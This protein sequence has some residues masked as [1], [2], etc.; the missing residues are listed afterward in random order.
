MG[1]DMNERLA[2]IEVMV[3]EQGCRLEHISS[4]MERMVRVE[5]RLASVMEENRHIHRR[6]DALQ[7]EIGGWRTAR[8]VFVWIAG[9]AGAVISG[10]SV[11]WLK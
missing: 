2:R 3:Q 4:V 6:I 5:E 10:L 9:I 11:W 1:E 8:R 7:D